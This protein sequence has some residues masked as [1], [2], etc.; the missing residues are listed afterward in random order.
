VTVAIIGLLNGL[1]QVTFGKR[2]GDGT[3][4]FD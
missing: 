2:R 3:V 4:A 1:N